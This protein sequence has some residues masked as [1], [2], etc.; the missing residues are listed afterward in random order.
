ML[1]KCEIYRLPNYHRRKT[2]NSRYVNGFTDSHDWET[3]GSVYNVG[4]E[5]VKILEEL[6]KK[7]LEVDGNLRKEDGGNHRKSKKRS[8]PSA[9]TDTKEAN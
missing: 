1:C 2:P 6:K 3:L 8:S 5:C 9:S 4:E 7:G